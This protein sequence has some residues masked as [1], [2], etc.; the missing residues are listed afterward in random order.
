MNVR[1]VA[2]TTTGAPVTTI[3][4]NFAGA[5]FTTDPGAA[6]TPPDTDGAVGPNAVVE[7]LN[8]V[9][10]VY[11]ESGGLL[12]T[13]SSQDFWLNAGATFPGFAFDPRVVYD[14]ASQRWFASSAADA[15]VPRK[16]HP[17]AVSNTSDPTQGWQAI[18][19]SGQPVKL[20]I[21]GIDIPVAV[22]TEIKPPVSIAPGDAAWS[23][24]SSKG[25]LKLAADHCVTVVFGGKQGPIFIDYQLPTPAGS[26]V[27]APG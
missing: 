3:G 16:P 2:A 23:A 21:S 20:S 13:S 11:D 1:M 5:N 9:Y 14:P 22:G 10:R 17:T 26:G 24:G 18:S 15:G 12:Q 6:F 4:A 7:L 25:T 8:N 27:R 19:I